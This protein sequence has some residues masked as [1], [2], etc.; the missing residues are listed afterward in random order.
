M[1]E[2]RV[3]KEEHSP[4]HF[5]EDWLIR[6]SEKWKCG[7]KFSCA[8]LSRIWAHLSKVSMLS[9][10]FIVFKIDSQWYS[11]WE[12]HPNTN[13]N[14]IWFQK[15]TRIRIRILVFGLKYSNNIRIPNY[16]LTSGRGGIK[17]G[18]LGNVMIN[19]SKN[20]HWMLKTT[21][22]RTQLVVKWQ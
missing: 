8:H 22:L 15:V 1:T 19:T 20:N 17:D 2:Y 14:N 3:L 16:S 5:S 10:I 7:D 4:T 9:K 13:T 6:S 21:R 12:N 11:V 18:Y